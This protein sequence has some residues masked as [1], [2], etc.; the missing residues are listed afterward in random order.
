[1]VGII[2]PYI[3]G[4]NLFKAFQYTGNGGA[5]D[6]TLTTNFNTSLVWLKS[7]STG[8]S[9][10]YNHVLIDEERGATKLLSPNT[11]GA[12][13]TVAFNL[14]FNPSSVTFGN[15]SSDT[16]INESATVYEAFVWK[17][18]EK[19]FDIVT[20]TGAG[21]ASTVINH[22]LGITPSMIIYKSRTTSNVWYVY[23]SSLASNQYIVLNSTDPA[24][25]GTVGF[26]STAPTST[27]FTVGTGAASTDDFV[28]Y[29][30]GEVTGKSAFGVYTG[31]GATS[32]PS[33]NLGWRPSLLL[34][35][36][37]ETGGTNGDW[38]MFSPVWADN[39]KSLVVNS[40]GGSFT[41]SPAL[42]T[43]TD[44]GFSVTS[45]QVDVNENTYDY[46][47]MAWK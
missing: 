23:L 14:A 31:N 25:T 7:F 16:K 35:K 17:Q 40:T 1:M 18:Q 11:T 38:R 36:K 2:N 26:N 6:I 44:T 42:V 28:A 5:S 4:G 8:G 21:T 46:A 34:V 33:V 27:Q 12:E 3:F 13:S 15:G 45:S 47:Y 37:V 43:L 39:T 41:N 19:F 30:F 24:Q 10:S 29:L 9:S 32:G 22:N 20:F